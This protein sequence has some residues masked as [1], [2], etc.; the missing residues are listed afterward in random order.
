MFLS[1][2][3]PNYPLLSATGQTWFAVF[4]KPFH[5]LVSAWDEAKEQEGQLA[6]S[7][8]GYEHSRH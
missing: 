5:V 8:N 7:N 2:D 3:N 1:V 6:G 4:N